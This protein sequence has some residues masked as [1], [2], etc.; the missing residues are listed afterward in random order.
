M[1]VAERTNLAA[2]YRY[3]EANADASVIGYWAYKRKGEDPRVSE[4][5]CFHGGFVVLQAIPQAHDQAPA[6][7]IYVSMSKER[8]LYKHAAYMLDVFANF[9]FQNNPES[10]NLTI[11]V[12]GNAYQAS[13]LVNNY[14]VEAMLA[15]G[16]LERVDRFGNHS[17]KE[18]SKITSIVLTRKR[19]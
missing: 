19:K 18:I 15:S 11:K 17:E 3:F 8:R 1:E 4:E 12:F 6:H 9:H 14:Q 13:V 10:E 16:T 7:M 5:I 2:F